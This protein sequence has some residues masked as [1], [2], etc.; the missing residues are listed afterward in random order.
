M[1]FMVADDILFKFILHIAMK[2][3]Y[4]NVTWKYDPFL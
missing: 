3:L 2:F 1:C 4:F